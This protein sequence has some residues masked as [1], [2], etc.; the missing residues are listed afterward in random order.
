M[1]AHGRHLAC[2]DPDQPALNTEKCARDGAAQ[3]IQTLLPT[4]PTYLTQQHLVPM[5]TSPRLR[6][7]TPLRHRRH[8]SAAGNAT[9]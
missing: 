6:P 3:P 5:P 4:E 9:E 8:P 1:G 2:L 7:S